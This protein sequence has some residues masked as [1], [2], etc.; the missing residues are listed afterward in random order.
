M[1][2][3]SV[4]TICDQ[5]TPDLTPN[6]GQVWEVQFSIEITVKWW[7]IERQAMHREVMCECSVC[8][9]SKPVL[10]LYIPYHVV[11]TFVS[12]A[13]KRSE[14]IRIRSVDWKL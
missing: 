14:Y 6:G 7:Q 12:N 5:N 4:G 10:N 8:G 1:V 13:P 9:H 11:H 3:I 2:D